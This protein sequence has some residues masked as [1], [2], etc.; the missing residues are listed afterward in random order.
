MFTASCGGRIVYALMSQLLCGQL[1]R[2]RKSPSAGPRRTGSLL[3]TNN[4]SDQTVI[5]RTASLVAQQTRFQKRL[6]YYSAHVI[7]TLVGRLRCAQ[8]PSWRNTASY[9]RRWIRI[10]RQYKVSYNDT[11]DPGSRAD[12][13]RFIGATIVTYYSTPLEQ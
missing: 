12:S 9:H 1:L 11:F 6:M 2:R 5:N 13:V 8:I 4:V 3:V 7:Y 10:I